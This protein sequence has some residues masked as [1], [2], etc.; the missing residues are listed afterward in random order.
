MPWSFFTSPPV[1]CAKRSTASLI[2][3]ALS[4]SSFAK[5]L[6]AVSVHSTRFTNLV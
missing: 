5:P 6:R 4:L 3:R 1:V 2:R